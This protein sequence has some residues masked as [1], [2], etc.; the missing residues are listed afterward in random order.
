M[1]WLEFERLRWDKGKPDTAHYECIACNGHI[2][3]HHKT[4]MLQTG[5]WRSTAE[6]ADPGT[7]GF[8]LSALYSPVGWFSWAD[9][10]R[11]WEAAQATDEAK[12]SFKNGVLGLTWVETG[13]VP[14]PT[15]SSTDRAA[16]SGRR[17]T[18]PPSPP[19]WPAPAS[20]R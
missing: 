14:T 11:M 6:G 8:H 1:Q 12:R 18:R 9:I 20:P 16:A 17:S 19:A 15:R 4:A 5:G 2:A 10:A 3:E 13:A 7:I